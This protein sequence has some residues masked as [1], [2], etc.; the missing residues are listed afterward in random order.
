LMQLLAWLWIPLAWHVLK[1][2][3]APHGEPPTLLVL[4]VFQRDAQIERLFDQVIER[5]RFTGNTVLIAGTDLM[6]RTID[7][8]DLFTYF[9]GRLAER[10]VATQEEVPQ[11]VAQLDMSPDPDGRYRVN[12]CYCFDTTWQAML[13][14]LVKKADVV[15]MDLRGFQEKNAGCL[16]ELGVL[17]QASH[18]QRVVLLH[19]ATTQRSVAEAAIAAA[20]AGRF[21]WLEEKKTAAGLTGKIMAA[22]LDGPAIAVVPSNMLSGQQT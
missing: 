7:P 16:H 4:R 17:A 21:H 12:E 9:N 10:F 3:L 19:D 20:P 5:W 2:Y 13:A 14:A 22:L 1:G 15:L 11:R 18:L 8:D 6:S